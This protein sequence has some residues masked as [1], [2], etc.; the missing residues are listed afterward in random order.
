MS[1]MK[2]AQITVRISPTI[3]DEW[4]G[5]GCGDFLEDAPDFDYAGG[6]YSVSLAC[7]RS[8]LA[9]CE[10]YTDRYG[11]EVGIGLRSAYRALGKQVRAALDAIE[12]KATTESKP[13]GPLTDAMRRELSAI[14]ETGEPHDW[15]GGGKLWFYAR[16]RVLFALLR[17]ALITSEIGGYVLTDAGRAAIEDKAPAGGLS[18]S[19]A[20]TINSAPGTHAATK[21]GELLRECWHAGTKRGFLLTVREVQ[22]GGVLTGSRLIVEVHSADADLFVRINGRDYRAPR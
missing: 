1:D 14:A 5:R 8:I 17:R 6:T 4:A 20:P 19:R 11:P 16:E 13:A 3:A 12:T 22:M 15:Y 7:A 21:R 2:Q 10:F 9:D 18:M